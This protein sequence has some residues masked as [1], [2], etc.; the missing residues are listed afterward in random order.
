MTAPSMTEVLTE[1]VWWGTPTLCACGW[2][3]PEPDTPTVVQHRA[4]VAD[5]LAD[6]RFGH[7]EDEIEIAYTLGYNAGRQW[8]ADR[9]EAAEAQVAAVRTLADKPA[10]ARSGTGEPIPVILPRDIR[11]ALDAPAPASRTTDTHEHSWV[12]H[13]NITSGGY[14]VAACEACECGAARLGLGR[15]VYLPVSGGVQE[16]DRVRAARLEQ[17]RHGNPEGDC[18]ACAA[19]AACE[20]ECGACPFA[21]DARLRA[22]GGDQ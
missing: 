12:P 4:H 7:V 1:H 9:A 5:A 21:R 2:D 8:M 17:C 10:A 14:V 18:A 20:G 19:C 22:Q 6:A 11:E 3:S 15:G 13:W 16:L